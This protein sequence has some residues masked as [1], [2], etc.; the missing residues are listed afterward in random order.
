VKARRDYPITNKVIAELLAREA[1][2][3]SYHLARAFRRAARSAFLWPREAI[4]VIENGESLTA[5]PGIGPYLEK[6]IRGWID[7]PQIARPPAIRRDFI[8]L[9]E[10]RALLARQPEWA[11]KLR[12]DLQMHTRWGDGSGAVSEMAEAGS[13]RGY[14]YLGITDHPK[15]LKIAGGINE[16]AL[17]KQSAEIDR[18]NRKSCCRLLSRSR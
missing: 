15:G 14:E 3:A 2:D 9:A 11:K 1:E 12:G 17:R 6:N 18:A 7:Q 5:L 10:A 4:E 13:A 16:A 8:T